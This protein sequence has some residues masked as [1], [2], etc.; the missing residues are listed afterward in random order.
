MRPTRPKQNLN[1]LTRLHALYYYVYEMAK[2]FG[3]N[4]VALDTIEKGIRDRQIVKRIIIKY[5]DSN[6][7][8]LG[9]IIIAIDWERHFV[10]AQT[11]DGK[12]F[13]VN[14]NKSIHSRISALSDIIIDHVTCM[15][16]SLPIKRITTSYDYVDEI[17]ND[18]EKHAA[19]RAYLGHVAGTAD[20]E[21]I[22]VEFTHT[23]EH[24]AQH[25]EEVSIKIMS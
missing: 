1:V 7:V 4:E 8:V 18:K 14:A 15:R 3:V 17:T 6:N 10:L 11:D 13:T 20:Q 25:L 21:D 2:A 23:F 24:I 22:Q 12:S 16:K 9:K 5:R 19:A